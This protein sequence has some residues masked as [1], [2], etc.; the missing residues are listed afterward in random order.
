MS[1]EQLS[2]DTDSGEEVLLQNPF[3]EEKVGEGGGIEIHGVVGMSEAGYVRQCN[4]QSLLG[5]S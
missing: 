3:D 2:A 5:S 4:V 1:F